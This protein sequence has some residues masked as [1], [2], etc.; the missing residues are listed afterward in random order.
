MDSWYIYAL[1]ALVFMGTQRFLY[2]VSAERRCNTAWTTS[3]FMATVAVMSAI[4]VVVVQEPVQDI[5][6]LVFISFLNSS[7]FLIGTITHIEVLK[8]VPAAV[9]YPIIR[10]N[11]VLVVIFSI[12]FFHDSVSYYQAAGIGFAIAVIVILTRPQQEDKQ[13]YHNINRSFV[14]IFIA[15]IS[16][17]IAAISS[18]FAAVHTSKMAFMAVSYAMSTVFSLGLRNRMQTRDASSDH[19]EALKIGFVMG[20]FNF[21]GFYAFL[22]ALAAGPLSIIA[23]LVGMHFVIA[24]ILSRLIYREKLTAQRILGIGLTILSIILLRL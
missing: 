2:K 14:F 9:V 6:F 1:L 20:L 7:T 23:A 10:L 3:A 16:G 5:R 11:V 18:K 15:M 19:K 4:G 21:A 12:L 24:V 17:S 22:K 13:A 8:H